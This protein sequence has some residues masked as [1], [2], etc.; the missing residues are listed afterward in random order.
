[1]VNILPSWGNPASFDAESPLGGLN[2]LPTGELAINL[3]SHISGFPVGILGIV[4]S[5][6]LLLSLEP[7][8]SSLPAV[9][10]VVRRLRVEPVDSP[11][12]SLTVVRD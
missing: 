8:G 6:G 12:E 7:Q 3:P 1:M 2:P 11:C 4:W 9:R 5:Q 10:P